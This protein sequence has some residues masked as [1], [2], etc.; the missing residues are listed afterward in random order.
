MNKRLEG[1]LK[2]CVIGVGTATA[3]QLTRRGLGSDPSLS[4]I[5]C[6]TA[7]GIAASVGATKYSNV[8]TKK[9]TLINSMVAGGSSLLT[10]ILIEVIL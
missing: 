1:I 7:S 9:S 5:Y 8:G 6:G 2:S 3:M 4:Y 10:Y